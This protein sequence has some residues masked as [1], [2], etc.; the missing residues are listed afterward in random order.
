MRGKRTIFYL[1]LFLLA[2]SFN[3][4]HAQTGRITGTVTDSTT[5]EA[6]FGANVFLEG[7]S[8]GAATDFEGNFRIGQVPAGS[9]VLIVRYI[10]YETK[11]IPIDVSA[12][13]TLEIDIALLSQVIEGEEV[14]VTAQA[15]G[16]KQ[17]INQQI[18]S[19]T[20][21]NIVSSEKIHELPDDNA[22]TA[23]SRLPGVSLMNGDQVVI[24][25]I[26]AKL[27]QVLINGIQMPSTD[28]ENRSTNL[29][30]ISSNMLSGIEVVKA[31]T[32][33]MDAN[34]VGGV[35]NLKLREAPSGFHFDVLTQGNYNY[36]DRNANNY[37]F[38]ASVS[39]RF[40]NDKL[41]VF[42]QGNVDRSDG[43]N[44]R[45][46]RGLA[47]DG[48]SNTTY[49]QAVYL[50]NRATFEYDRDIVKIGGA[51]V[52]LDYKL[53]DGKIVLQ[54]T[55]A[56]NFSDQRHHMNLLDFD[57]TEAVYTM[58]RNKYGRDLWINALQAENNFGDIKVEAS[59]SHSSTKQY[60]RMAYE[61]RYPGTG[62]TDFH[63]NTDFKAPFGVDSDSNRITYNSR[64]AQTQMTM[65]R[66]YRIFDNLNYDDV[67]RATL[68][69]WV[70]SINNI[71]YQ[72]LYNSTLD[73]TV[74]IKFS[75][76][77]TAELKAGGKYVLTTRVND[78]D[79]YFSPADG[80]ATYESVT[81]YFPD[82][83]RSNTNRLRFTDVMKT[84]FD[85]GENFLSDEYDFSNGFQ[86]VIDTDIYDD[87]LRQSQTGWSP[88]IKMDD[89][90]KDD[91]GGEESFAAGYI[92][93]TFDIFQKLTLLTGVRYESYNMKYD[94][95][96]TF[97]Q[98]SVFGDAISTKVGTIVDDPD[99][100]WHSVPESY[101]KVD[102]TDV[103]FF[104]NAILTYQVNDWWDLRF[105]YTTGISRPDYLAIIPRVAVFPN[106]RFEVG[107][108]KLKPTTSNNFDIITSFYSNE[109]GLLTVNFFYKELTDVMYNT[110]IYYGNLS[111][112][113]GNINIPDSAFMKDRFNYNTRPQDLVQTS[114]NNPNTGYI[115]GIEIGWQTNFWYLPQPLNSLVLDVNY[116]KSGSNINYNIIRNVPERIIDPNTGRPKNIYNTV[117]TVYSGRLIQHAEDVVNVALGVDYKGFSGRIS[118][119]MRGN[120]LNSVG[121]RPE[122]SSY[123]G[124]IYRWDFTIR[125]RLP[126]EGLSVSLNGVNIFHN[127]VKSYRN[128]RVN[129]DAP[130][131]E[132]LV[133]VYYPPTIYQLSLRYS[134]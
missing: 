12:G 55:Y 23:L 80:S 25:G 81:N 97:V 54:N 100:L 64:T 88:G 50:T 126:F 92:M 37:K 123:T 99:T 122:E 98:H 101:Y 8:L 132:N 1:L 10:G 86:Y 26:E 70:S 96:F 40:F 110:N 39:N 112:Y 130:I 109:I 105:A 3:T 20:I 104:P 93:G 15:L 79:R 133:S 134:F 103:N 49:G 90:W 69:G 63:N 19:N 83:P 117:D 125:Q 34:T 107:N 111:D 82:R 32:P 16:Q 9:Q 128:Y 46:E 58:D 121:T 95:N 51:S 113:A 2:L 45:A 94:G 76:D 27:N 18:T 28:M 102:R 66:A 42:I 33:D 59:L 71:F 13:Q 14:T 72:H 114:L 60:T 6:L 115:R 85:R 120:V 56:G 53:P 41:G 24:R 67:E 22:A 129:T 38:W 74:P 68:E 29:G 65:E 116:T 47:I 31:I 44:Q 84:D 11:E 48:S 118:F 78:F 106:A 4:I 62:W 57:A 7:L 17:A 131:T 87:W 5:G 21:K 73:V 89:S 43:G 91:W 124:N 52:I 108:P 30:F 35:V 36:S 127:G 77:F 119:N 75:N 61:P